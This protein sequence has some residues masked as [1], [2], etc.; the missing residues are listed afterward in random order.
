[1]TA[2]ERVEVLVLLVEQVGMQ[3]ELGSWVREAKDEEA[4]EIN[5]AGV[6]CQVNYLL[7]S[8]WPFGTLWSEAIRRATAQ[9]PV[10][11]GK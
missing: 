10:S 4:A 6:A 9:P 1:M 7:E 11:N 5:A 3:E 8:G 2:E